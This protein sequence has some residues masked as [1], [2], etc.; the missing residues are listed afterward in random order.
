MS[1]DR[2]H[3]KGLTKRE[4][5][6]EVAWMMR[7]V[8]SEPEALAKLLVQVIVALIDKNNAALAKH[9]MHHDDHKPGAH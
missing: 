5:E 9:D 1:D 4:L 6:R 2:A 3:H 8:P 7:H